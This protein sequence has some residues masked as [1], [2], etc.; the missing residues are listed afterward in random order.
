MSHR[1]TDD[2]RGKDVVTADGDRIGTVN[3]V[4]DDHATVDRDDDSSLTDK[5]K[6][7]LGWGDDDS[8]EIRDEHV[9]R[10]SDDRITLRQH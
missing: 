8:N 2:D 4:H 3:D 6:D 10:T 7:M 5:V 1:F 9:D